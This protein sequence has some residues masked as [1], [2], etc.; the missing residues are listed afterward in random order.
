MA[1]D[2]TRALARGQPRGDRWL[3]LSRPG[4]TRRG[5]CCKIGPQGETVLQAVRRPLLEQKRGA[6]SARRDCLE[7]PEERRRGRG[8]GGTVEMLSRIIKGRIY[9]RSR[10]SD[11]TGET[12]G[13]GEHQGARAAQTIRKYRISEEPDFEGKNGH[14]NCDMGCYLDLRLP[15]FRLNNDL[16]WPDAVRAMV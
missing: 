16:K 7:S 3:L 4:S 13:G 12:R 9:V 15:L 8:D 1:V 10:R 5:I 14:I 2:F 11:W 6:G